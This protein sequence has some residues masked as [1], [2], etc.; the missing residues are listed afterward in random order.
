MESHE[1]GQILNEA[2]A[3]TRRRLIKGL[4]ESS[5]KSELHKRIVY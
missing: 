1:I 4:I 5:Q 3:P 2:H